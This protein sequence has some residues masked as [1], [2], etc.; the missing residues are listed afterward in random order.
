MEKSIRSFEDSVDEVFHLPEKDWKL[1]SP[2]TLAYI[3]DAVYEMVVR[4]IYVKRS[5]MQTQKLHQKVTACVKAQTQAKMIQ[6]LLPELT[7]EK[8]AIYRRGRNSKP[9]T[10]AKNASLDEYLEATGFEAVVGYLYLNR[11]FDRMQ[12]LIRR[13]MEQVC[14]LKVPNQA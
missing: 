11:E 5:N 7:E 14:G 1:Y 12:G 3:G 10:K 4:S 6:L 13:G 8:A 9:H 2:L